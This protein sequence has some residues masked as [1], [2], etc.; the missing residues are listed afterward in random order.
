MNPFFYQR[1]K[2]GKR[3]LTTTRSLPCNRNEE[4]FWGRIQEVREK[5]RALFNRTAL[6]ISNATKSEDLKDVKI[7][8]QNVPALFRSYL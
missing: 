8:S 1:E 4:G 6:D 5:G 2:V 3:K 7:V